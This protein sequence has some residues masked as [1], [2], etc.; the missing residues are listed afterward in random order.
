MLPTLTYPTLRIFLDGMLLM[1]ALYAFATYIWHRKRIYAYYGLYI[2]GMIANLYFNDEAH[3]L[4]DQHATDRAIALAS[5]LEVTI[6]AIAFVFYIQFARTLLNMRQRDP[7]SLRLSTYMLVVLAIGQLTDT[8]LLWLEPVNRLGGWAYILSDLNRYAM[9]ALTF[10]IVPRILRQRNMVTSIFIIGTS[11]FVGGSILAVTM[12][13]FGWGDRLPDQPF[14][15]P[16]IPMQLGI[17]IESLLFTVA[18]SVVNRQIEREKIRY[19]AQLIEQLQENEQ[20]QARL[21]G[22]RDEIARDLHDEMGSQLSS[23]SILSQTTMRYVED[24]RA[25][26]RLVTIGQTTRQVMDSMR[27]IVWS[28]N[29]SSD[30][31]QHLSLRIGETAYGLFNDTTIR[32]HADLAKTDTWHGLTGKKRRELHLIAKECLTNVL[33]HANAQNVWLTLHVKPD[34][35]LLSIRDD[36]TGFDPATDISGLGLRSIQQRTRTLGAKLHIDTEP[37]GGTSIRIDCPIQQGQVEQES[38]VPQFA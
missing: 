2:G 32:L 18:I 21:N 10:M 24:E 19:Q 12:N 27:E 25:Q 22:L 9:A 4:I 7:V 29:S 34:N 37:G 8:L 16:L 33:R 31:I 35:V 36:G 3:H 6:Q 28:L 17:V 20:K 15:F 5:W 38:V 30:T 13:L 26:Q 14:S 11:F 23:I 1:M